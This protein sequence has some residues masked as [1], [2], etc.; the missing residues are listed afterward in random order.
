M[1]GHSS[2]KDG[3][4]SLAYV[5]AIHDLL[6]VRSKMWMAWSSPGMT[7]YVA[8]Y[9]TEYGHALLGSPIHCVWCDARS[10]K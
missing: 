1:A 8:R 7:E 4:A 2:P 5:P 6:L 10:I 3:V 9:R